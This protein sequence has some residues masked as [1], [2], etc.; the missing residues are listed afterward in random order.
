MIQGPPGTGKTSTISSLV[1][2]EISYYKSY[3]KKIRYRL[4]FSSGTDPRKLGTEQLKQFAVTAGLGFPIIMPRE[5]TSYMHLAFEY[6][7]LYS[8]TLSE[9]S[10]RITVGFTLNDNT[11]FLK[12]KYQ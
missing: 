5:Q 10:V 2:A 6:G 1:A 8:S 12:R 4:G 11:W 3:R 9:E 7:K